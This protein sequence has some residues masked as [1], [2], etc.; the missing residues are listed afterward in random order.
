[1]NFLIFVVLRS[2]LRE[3]CGTM[4]SMYDTKELIDFKNITH[5]FGIQNISNHVQFLDKYFNE[6]EQ[7]IVET[8]KKN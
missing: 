7:L 6:E 3:M 1:M 8:L 4:D 2:V 5:T